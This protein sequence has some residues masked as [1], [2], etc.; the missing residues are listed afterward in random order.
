[1]NSDYSVIINPLTTE[2]S[3]RMMESQNKLVFIVAK[4]S[5]KRSI[6]KAI[7]SMFNVKV[8]DVNTHLRG[9]KKIAF[10]SLHPDFNAM[11]IA[12]QLGIL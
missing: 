3:V 5:T 4:G 9:G 1:M 2:K 8:S 11:D 10:I 6:K 12:T 7:E